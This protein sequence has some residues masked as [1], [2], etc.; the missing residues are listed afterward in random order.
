VHWDL[1]LRQ[2]PEAGGGKMWFDDVL[3]RDDGAFV[4]DELKPLNPEA[5]R[6]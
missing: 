5:L 6:A 4:L 2:G 1:V 3:V